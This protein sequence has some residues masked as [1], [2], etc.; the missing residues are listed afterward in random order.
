MRK[1][2]ENFKSLAQGD[3]ELSIKFDLILSR[4]LVPSIMVK[5]PGVGVKY[6]IIEILTMEFWESYLNFPVFNSFFR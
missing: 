1:M 3:T 6:I 5:N 2:S 4:G